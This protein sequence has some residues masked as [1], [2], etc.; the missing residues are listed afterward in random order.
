MRKKNIISVILL[1]FAFDAMAFLGGGGHTG[2]AGFSGGFS[3]H[4]HHNN[5]H[6]QT[7]VLDKFT[8]IFFLFLL[9]LLLG[10]YFIRVLYPRL[11]DLLF[12]HYE[13]I[14]IIFDFHIDGICQSPRKRPFGKFYDNEEFLMLLSTCTHPPTSAEN[15]NILKQQ[16]NIYTLM[17]Q[18]TMID[19]PAEV[20]KS[21]PQGSID[22]L[23]EKAKKLFIE[24]EQ[25]W[26]QQNI[27]KLKRHIRSE[28]FKDKL[29]DQ[30][31]EFRS[32]GVVNLIKKTH[33]TTCILVSQEYNPYRSCFELNFMI[34]GTHVDEYLTLEEYNKHLHYEPRPFN[35]IAVFD[36]HKDQLLF[37][38]V[39]L[40][41][42]GLDLA[43][44]IYNN[45]ADRNERL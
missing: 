40:E 30:I 13:R 38:S 27:S 7:I 45:N 21:Q 8:V 12:Y 6:D 16:P 41:H 11:K 32:W 35:V 37:H 31:L 20:L 17:E 14:K 29:I 22:E 1:S 44:A 39:Y 36:L 26:A 24:V 15:I 42:H 19:L 33:I 25:Y 2:G 4:R 10:S 34:E 18:R 3:S 9:L 23:Y 5:E 28:T 43:L